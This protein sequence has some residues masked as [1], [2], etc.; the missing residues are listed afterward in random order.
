L[1][2]GATGVTCSRCPGQIDLVLDCRSAVLGFLRL[3]GLLPGPMC[4]PGGQGVEQGTGAA[5]LQVLLPVCSSRSVLD[6]RTFAASL[7]PR[8]FCSQADETLQHLL[9]GY[10]FSREVWDTLLLLVPRSGGLSQ[11]CGTGGCTTTKGSPRTVGGVLTPLSLWC[12]GSFGRSAMISSS[13]VL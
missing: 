13:I 6:F 7:P 11:R 3:Q 8:V 12:P 9:L 10:S 5:V 2:E 4:H 1:R